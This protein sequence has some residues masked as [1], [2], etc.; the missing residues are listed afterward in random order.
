M[1]MPASVSSMP[2]PSY[3]LGLFPICMKFPLKTE[4]QEQ[5]AGDLIRSQ[6][7]FVAPFPISLRPILWLWFHSNNSSG[8]PS[9]N[10]RGEQLILSNSQNSSETVD[11]SGQ[12]N[13]LNMS[14]YE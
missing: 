2:M 4:V 3:E 12:D 5:K 11:C 1:P 6:Q 14:A 13:M 7:F 8:E 9:Y 10:G